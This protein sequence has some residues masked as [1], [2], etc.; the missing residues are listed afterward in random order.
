MNRGW[1]R[2]ETGYRGPHGNATGAQVAA[3][4]IQLHQGRAGRRGKLHGRLR[5]HHVIFRRNDDQ[6]LRM[7]FGGGLFQRGQTEFAGN[8]ERNNGLALANAITRRSAIALGTVP[9]SLEKRVERS[10]EHTSE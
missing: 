9:Y 10:E 6:E 3:W 8:V 7:N 4:G 1:V 5:R 2:Q